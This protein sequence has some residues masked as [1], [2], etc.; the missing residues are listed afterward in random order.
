MLLTVEGQYKN[1]RI[2]LSEAPAGVQE[3]KVIVTF[4]PTAPNGQGQS[5]I[6]FGM[7]KGERSTEPEDFRLAEWRESSGK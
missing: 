2:S 6:R 1:G 4:L 7:F 5:K 3:A